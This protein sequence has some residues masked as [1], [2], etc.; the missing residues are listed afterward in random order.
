MF[1]LTHKNKNELSIRYTHEPFLPNSLALFFSPSPQLQSMNSLATSIMLSKSSYIIVQ[2]FLIPSATRQILAHLPVLSSAT[3]SVR[4][5]S[6][7][8]PPTG[9]AALPALGSVV[10]GLGLSRGCQYISRPAAHY[11]NAIS[12]NGESL[13]RGSINRTFRARLDDFERPPQ[14]IK[15]IMLVS[16]SAHWPAVVSHQ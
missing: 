16:S 8:P 13:E 10:P 1:S 3:P 12:P 11:L 2:F 4:S 7:P 9:P 6:R 14:S 15:K 5:S